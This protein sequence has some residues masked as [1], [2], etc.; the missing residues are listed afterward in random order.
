MFKFAY[1]FL[2]LCPILL[3]ATEVLH[4]VQ[5]PASFLSTETSMEIY[6][7]V[8]GVDENVSLEYAPWDFISIYTDASFRFL[9]YSYEISTKGYIHNYCNLHQHGFNETY[10][11]LKTFFLDLFGVNLNW[12]FPPGEGLQRERFHRLN[13]EPY[14]F[15]SF[16]NFLR[17]GLSIRYN[18]FLESEN[19]KPGDEFGIKGSLSWNFFWID[20]MFIGWQMDL[21]VL[22][23]QRIMESENRNLDKPYQKMKDQYKGVKAKIELMRHFDMFERLMAIGV[24]FEYHMGTIFG[25]EDGYRVGLKF[26][27]PLKKPKLKRI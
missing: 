4:P 6:D 11:G 16:S 13:V 3:W 23:Q 5:A 25:F 10:L 12:R 17:S 15:Y 20:Y 21:S 26:E 19:Y 27:L 9:G 24:N 22:Y 7:D 1:C 8:Y 2:V 14:L 18:T